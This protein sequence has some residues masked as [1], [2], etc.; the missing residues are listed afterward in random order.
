MADSLSSKPYLAD[1]FK[2][3]LRPLVTMLVRAGVTYNDFAQL[4]QGVYIESAFR[5]GFEPGIPRSVARV[6]LATGLNRSVIERY[7]DNPDNSAG[8]EPTLNSVLAEVVHRWNTM[9]AYSGPYGVTIELD[10]DVTPQRNFVELVQS[11]GTQISPNAVLSELLAAGVVLSINGET[12]YK[13]VARTF[14]FQDALSPSMMEYFGNVMTDLA[15]TVE[16]NT[17]PRVVQKRIERSVF[18]DR[19]LTQAQLEEFEE[20]ARARVPSLIAELDDYLATAATKSAA[21]GDGELID[22]GVNIF[23][24]VRR[25]TPEPPLKALVGKPA[26]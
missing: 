19:G 16:H 24:Y 21:T 18:A 22:V 9:P 4:L 15:A 13:I 26:D 3:I 1:A 2:K 17:R 5:G 6:S 25:R 20:F 10:Y 14:V 12:R 23:Q 11:T 8:R 7:L